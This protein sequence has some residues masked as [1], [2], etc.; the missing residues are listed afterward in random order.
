MGLGNGW[1]AMGKGG[2]KGH[3]SERRGMGTGAGKKTK[4][5]RAMGLVGFRW[6]K[7]GERRRNRGGRR[8][9]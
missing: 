7:G 4:G 8:C 1:V 2:E 3:G 6:G 5:R 9:L